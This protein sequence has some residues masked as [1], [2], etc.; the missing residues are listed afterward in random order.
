MAY[1]GLNTALRNRIGVVWSDIW[2]FISH[3]K[4]RLWVIDDFGREHG[5]HVSEKVSDI[6]LG[7]LACFI[8]KTFRQLVGIDAY[9]HPDIARFL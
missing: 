1:S 9:F 2:L 8:I 4:E 3:I 6:G 7:E 5:I